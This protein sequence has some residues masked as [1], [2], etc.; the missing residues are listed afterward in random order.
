M[1]ETERP[2]PERLGDQEEQERHLTQ[3]GNGPTVENEEALLAEVF[4]QADT[5]GF[6]TGPELAVE[7]AE[8][9]QDA[10]ADATDGGAA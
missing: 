1:S 8:A 7:N 4:G 10:P 5:A 6:F 3:T 2:I 9:D